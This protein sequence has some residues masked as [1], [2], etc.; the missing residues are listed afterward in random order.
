MRRLEEKRPLA[1]E[2]NNHATFRDGIGLPNLLD[3]FNWSSNSPALTALIS[4]SI[5]PD[6]FSS[7]PTAMAA[8]PFSN[9]MRFDPI[10]T[11]M[12]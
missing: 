10:F 11:V 9:S 5:T 8:F 7:G 6:N 3:W 2:F 12:T 4:A 1:A